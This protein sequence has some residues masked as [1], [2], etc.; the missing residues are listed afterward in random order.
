LA[1]ILLK[2]ELEGTGSEKSSMFFDG[3]LLRD[4]VR[5]GRSGGSRLPVLKQI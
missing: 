2:L 3:L 5:R 1:A 4:G